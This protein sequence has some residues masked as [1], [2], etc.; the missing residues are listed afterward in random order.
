MKERHDFTK[1]NTPINRAV[2]TLLST[3]D[4]ELLAV[5]EDQALMGYIHTGAEILITVSKGDE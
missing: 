2:H 3:D 4:Y 1:Q 5:T